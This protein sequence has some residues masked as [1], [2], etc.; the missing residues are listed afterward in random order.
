MK[1]NINIYNLF[2]RNEGAG[3]TTLINK[4]EGY[5]ECRDDKEEEQEKKEIISTCGFDQFEIEL[6]ETILSIYDFAG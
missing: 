2:N 5:S 4:I 1:L 3:K 6:Q